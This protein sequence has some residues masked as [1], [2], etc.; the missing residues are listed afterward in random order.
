[1]IPRSAAERQKVNSRA[2]DEISAEQ[3]SMATPIQM[4]NRIRCLFGIL[5]W[6]GAS[7]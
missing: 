2:A 5:G 6:G 4:A 7:S 3:E 1:M